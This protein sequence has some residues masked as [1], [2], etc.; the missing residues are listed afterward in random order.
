M[1]ALL[2]E[3]R[4]TIYCSYVWHYLASIPCLYA[5]RGD[6]TVNF[7]CIVGHSFPRVL[8]CAAMVHSNIHVPIQIRLKYLQKGTN[9]S[10]R[11]D[12]PLHEYV[13]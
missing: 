11:A 13:E 4:Y 7:P 12:E 8:K 9:I 6:R 5:Y 1:A 3:R 10:Q 2:P